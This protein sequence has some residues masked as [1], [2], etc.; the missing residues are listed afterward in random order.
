KPAVD[1]SG[2]LAADNP[3]G[4][5]GQDNGENHSNNRGKEDKNHWLQPA[6]EDQR[7]EPCVSNSSAAIAADES[8]GRTGGEAKNKGD[9]VP[10]N[11]AKQAGQENLLVDQF[12][13]NHAFA[14]G[15]GDGRAKNKGGDKIPEGGPDDGAERRQDAGG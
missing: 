12:D 15:A 8:V 6:R 11:R 14:D 3:A 2:T 4:E 13:V 7:L 1:P 9:Q 10:G 5:D